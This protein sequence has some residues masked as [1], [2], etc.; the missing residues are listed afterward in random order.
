MGND[1]DPLR[2]L[3][4]SRFHPFSPRVKHCHS[5][6]PFLA[7]PI[8]SIHLQTNSVKSAWV[9]TSSCTPVESGFHLGLPDSGEWRKACG[10]NPS[11]HLSCPFLTPFP[12]RS[13][14][15]LQESK[16]SYLQPIPTGSVYA[17]DGMSFC[18]LG[19][20]F[21]ISLEKETYLPVCQALGCC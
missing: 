11:Q 5:A 1:V 12:T 6:T 10:A 19:V 15:V 20:L 13:P 18:S 14:S 2:P 7:I 8:C 4:A 3:P 21:P 9:S 16:M 17:L